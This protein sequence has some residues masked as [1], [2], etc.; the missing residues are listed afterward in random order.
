MCAIGRVC[1]DEERA[2]LADPELGNVGARRQPGVAAEEPVEA[3]RAE[4]GELGQRLHRDRLAIVR[5]DVVEHALDPRLVRRVRRHPA[6]ARP[7]D[8][9]GVLVLGE[10]RE[11]ADQ[12]E[13]PLRRRLRG[14]R[15][16]RGTHRRCGLAGEDDAAPGLAEHRRYAAHLGERAGEARAPR[17]GEPHHQRVVRPPL[18]DPLR[19]APGVRQV[20][21]EQHEVAVVIGGDRIADVALAAAVQ[22][23]RQLEFG[24]VVPLEGDAVVELSVEQRPRRALRHRHLLEQRTH[25]F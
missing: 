15:L 1:V 3:R 19:R 11:H 4:A 20:R 7:G 13:E 10:R 5:V 14:D 12:A 2:G 8:R 6:R 23:Q 25:R 21:P 18:R 16:D 22:R 17:L 24:V 9:P